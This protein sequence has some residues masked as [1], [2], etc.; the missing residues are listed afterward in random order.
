MALI[1][2]NA[3]ASHNIDLNEEEDC[4]LLASCF[5]L[6]TRLRKLFLSCGA[7]CLK[8]K[9]RETRDRA[10]VAQYIFFLACSIL[11]KSINQACKSGLES[12]FVYIIEPSSILRMAA[13]SIKINEIE[14][15]FGRVWGKWAR[16]VDGRTK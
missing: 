16:F 1:A 13:W 2:A 5:F 3:L 12:Y 11:V 9:Q 8:Q 15:G 6:L 4:S 10:F 14:I 7:R